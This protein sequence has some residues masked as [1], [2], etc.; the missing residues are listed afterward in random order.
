MIARR[1]S[2]AIDWETLFRFR[3]AGV[4]PERLAEAREAHRASVKAWQR[5]RQRLAR[6]GDEI[7]RRR[8]QEGLRHGG[9]EGGRRRRDGGVPAR[10]PEPEHAQPGLRSRPAGPG[11]HGQ[12]GGSR[13]REPGGM[14]SRAAFWYLAR[15]YSGQKMR[16]RVTGTGFR[17]ETSYHTPIIL[18][19]YSLGRPESSDALPDEGRMGKLGDR[20]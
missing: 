16:G 15:T 8:V 18:A 3:K 10:P 13:E 17:P 2:R 9:V 4:E 11:A 12:G 7:S 1:S 6:A 19:V 5:I 14:T 20:R